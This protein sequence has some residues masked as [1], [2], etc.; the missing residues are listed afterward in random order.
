MRPGPICMSCGIANDAAS[1]FCTW[2]G[3]QL[4]QGGKPPISRTLVAAAVALVLAAAGVLAFFLFG[5][6]EASGDVVLYEAPLSAGSRPFTSPVDVSAARVGAKIPALPE[7]SPA[8][9]RASTPFGGSGSNT[10]CDRERLVAFLTSHPDRMAAWARVLGLEADGVP[11]YVRS[12]RPATLAADTRFTNHSFVNGAAVPVQSVLPAGTAVLVDS[13]GKVVVRCRCG[14][15]LLP[16]KPVR[17]VCRGCPKGY[18]MPGLP[19]ARARTPVVFVIDPPPVGGALAGT[20]SLSVLGVSGAG[21]ELVSSGGD[22]VVRQEGE[23]LTVT[24]QDLTGSGSVGAD[25]S[26]EL[27]VTGSDGRTGTLRGRIADGRVQGQLDA[28][29]CTVL[30]EGSKT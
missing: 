8:S 24:A 16:P 12:L 28:F 20:Y 13:E 17:G 7:P 9:A 1:T 5:R 6:S 18:K 27:T 19:T 4:G 2:C 25:G 14:N 11:A 22:L 15:P 29:G 3:A 30:F 10:V 23:T 21:C 26:F